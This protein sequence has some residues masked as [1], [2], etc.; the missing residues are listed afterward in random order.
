VKTEKDPKKTDDKRVY[1]RPQLTV[2]GSVSNITQV[3]NKDP[4]FIDNPGAPMTM[5]G[6]GSNLPQGS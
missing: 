1:R 5:V 6:D 2:F 4:A 3:N